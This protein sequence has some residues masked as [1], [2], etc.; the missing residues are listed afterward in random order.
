MG[1]S[2][3]EQPIIADATRVKI[4][5]FFCFCTRKQ[6]IVQGIAESRDL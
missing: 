2:I 6:G 5:D 3:S 1:G 4:R